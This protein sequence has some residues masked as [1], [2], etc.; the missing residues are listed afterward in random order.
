MNR[1]IQ[2]QLFI[3]LFISC[4]SVNNASLNDLDTLYN[5]KFTLRNGERN[6]ISNEKE[7][8]VRLSTSQNKFI[9]KGWILPHAMANNCAIIFWRGN[10]KMFQERNML[11]VELEIDGTLPLTYQYSVKELRD[12][13]KDYEQI[14]TTIKSFVENTKANNIAEVQNVGYVSNGQYQNFSS[15]FEAFKE[16][17]PP[18][19]KDTKLVSF[20]ANYNNGVTEY[21]VEAVL[22]TYGKNRNVIHASLVHFNDEIKIREV[23]F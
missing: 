6:T 8:Y 4:N 12:M 14:E 17:I 10:P 1:I 15:F 7:D 19:Y 16:I 13:I 5:A 11:E 21:L 2:V 3:L 20:T 22:M 18:N 9:E 23:N